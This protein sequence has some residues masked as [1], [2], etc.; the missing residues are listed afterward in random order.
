MSCRGLAFGIG[1]GG[2]GQCMGFFLCMKE[3]VTLFECPPGGRGLM[4]EACSPGPQCPRHT[5]DPD[6]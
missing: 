1:G 2:G 3:A 4:N 6:T 5:V